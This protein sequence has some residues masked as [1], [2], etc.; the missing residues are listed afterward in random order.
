M[1]KLKELKARGE[2]Q[3][4]ELFPELKSEPWLRQEMV[5]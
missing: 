1:N 2:L 5:S 3:K 4:V